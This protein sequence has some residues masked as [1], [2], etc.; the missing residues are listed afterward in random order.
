MDDPVV[1]NYN[2][3]FDMGGIDYGSPKH[4]LLFMHASQGITFDLEAIRKANSTGRITRFLA[5]G[6]NGWWSDNL[7]REKI[8]ADLW[9]FVDGQPRFR[10][11][12]ISAADG[13]F[14]IAVP[15]DDQQRFLTLVTT[16]GGNGISY[17][18]T[19]F[20]DP[21]LEVIF[22]DASPPRPRGEEGNLHHRRGEKGV[23]DK[24]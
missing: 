14:R 9:V 17:D 3:S 7:N 1:R 19:M 8:S 23:P 24:Q 16:D 22:D 21:R 13:P 5:V 12:R 4:S 11:E 15:I 18:W 10:R 2:P 6:G 20:G